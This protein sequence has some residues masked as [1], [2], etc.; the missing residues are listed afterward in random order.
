MSSTEF[1]V[2]V[3]IPTTVRPG[4]PDG[5]RIVVE[6]PVADL[7]ELTRALD[8]Q[9]PGL[10]QELASTLYTFAVND[11]IIL[12]GKKTHPIRSGDRVEVM[13]IFAGGSWP[14]GK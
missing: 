8:R 1:R 10:G 5:G 4:L 9:V 3:F 2:E 13:P 7:G 6:E 14:A 12:K 11:E